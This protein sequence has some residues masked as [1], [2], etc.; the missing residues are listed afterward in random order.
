VRAIVATAKRRA[1][2]STPPVAAA[3]ARRRGRLV[4]IGGP[5]G[6]CRTE[7]AIALATA[8]AVATRVVLV[9]ADDVA[10]AIAQRLHL[11]IE[12]NLRTAI[13]AVEHGRGEL[14]ACILTDARSGV[15][16]VG[17]VP[18][19]GAWRHVRPGEIVRV[20]DRVAD[21]ADIVIADVGGLLEQVLDAHR[22]RYA[23]TR[24]LV[25]EADL[26]VAVC[27]AAPHGVTRLLSW[28]AEAR[29]LAPGTPVI[30]VV[31]RAPP[32]RYVRG[33]LYAE[34][35]ATID[36]VE[37]VFAA[38]DPRVA[39]AAWNGTT[40]TPGPFTRGLDRVAGLVAELVGAMA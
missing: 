28:I 12:P 14:D 25:G 33:E 24:A 10:P 20:V 8:L 22:A 35:V 23:T 16:V 29:P 9:D 40:V 36:P 26:L 38:H 2:R 27:D 19:A 39:D 21:A 7:V 1:D 15:A 5:P 34:I 32:A 3:P 6:T 18:N 4:T 30:V 31:N 13:D 17:G 37:V 11:P